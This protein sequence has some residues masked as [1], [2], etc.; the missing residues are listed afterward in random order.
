MPAVDAPKLV[1]AI[2]VRVLARYVL[3]LAFDDGS[4]KVI[5]I[6]DRLT[7]P[8]F[9]W[10]LD[11]YD[12]FRAVCVDSDSGTIRFPNGAE[13]SSAGLWAAARPAVPA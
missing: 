8:D 3:E 10:L 5:D 6:E 1:D 12:A 9:A 2:H 11:D 7:G 13:L 4:V